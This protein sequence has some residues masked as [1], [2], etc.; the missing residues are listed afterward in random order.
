VEECT[1]GA[2]GA[3]TASTGHDCD[4]GPRAE[5]WTE[6]D[7]G[8][9]RTPGA[10]ADCRCLRRPGSLGGHRPAVRSPYHEPY[11]PVPE[12][13]QSPYPS[14][15]VSPLNEARPGP[16]PSLRARRPVIGRVVQAAA[17]AA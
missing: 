13:V 5:I 9:E 4:V 14:P 11:R 7:Y 17:A 2:A 12:T 8:W 3:R 1:R 16:F 10:G 15:F 6:D